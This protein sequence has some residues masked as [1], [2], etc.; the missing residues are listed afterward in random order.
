MTDTSKKATVSTLLHLLE[1]VVC[2]AIAF[3]FLLVFPEFRTI[4]GT[5]I[6]GAVGLLLAGVVKFERANQSNGVPDYVN[7]GNKPSI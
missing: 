6:A 5:A 4:L 1:I 3:S 7:D 2:F